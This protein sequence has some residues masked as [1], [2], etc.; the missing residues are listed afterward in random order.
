MGY[1]NFDCNVAKCRFSEP[2]VDRRSVTE[3]IPA[4]G[5][6]DEGEASPDSI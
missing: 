5:T 3:V 4:T 2:A 1:H 6:P